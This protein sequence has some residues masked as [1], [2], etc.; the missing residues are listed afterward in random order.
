[1]AEDVLCQSQLSDCVLLRELEQAQPA[2]EANASIFEVLGLPC[3]GTIAEYSGCVEVGRKRL[4]FKK[5]FFA[6]C[7]HN[8]LVPLVWNEALVRWSKAGLLPC[9]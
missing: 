7:T 2:L 5:I 1:M 9:L 3:A 8:S 6:R 4:V